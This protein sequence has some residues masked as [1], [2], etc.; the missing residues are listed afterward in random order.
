[1]S[2]SDSDSEKSYCSD[3]SKFNY[4]P[5]P[6]VIEAVEVEEAHSNEAA[7]PTDDNL[8][9][10][11]FKPYEDEPMA[12]EQWVSEYQ[13]KQE[14]QAVFERKLQDRYEGIQ[15]VNSW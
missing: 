11:T 2:K 13:K 9:P 12:S 10:H 5:G 15:V 14:T 6:Y 3:D 8:D 7:W 1:M 4:I